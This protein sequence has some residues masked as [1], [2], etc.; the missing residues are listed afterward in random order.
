MTLKSYLNEGGVKS[1]F[2]E[3]AADFFNAPGRAI[4]LGKSVK[5]ASGVV[6][7]KQNETL[8]TK[9]Q[10]WVNERGLYSSVTRP[11]KGVLGGVAYGVISILVGIP[12][13]VGLGLKALALKTNDKA[14]TFHEV[15]ETQLFKERVEN[16]RAEM[17][18][19]LQTDTRQLV[20]DVEFFYTAE[21]N[22]DFMRRRPRQPAAGTIH[23]ITM[24]YLP[25]I[26]Q[27]NYDE[28]T[29]DFVRDL[30]VGASSLSPEVEK[31]LAKVLKL[32]R[33][34]PGKNESV[35]TA[36]NLRNDALRR[37]TQLS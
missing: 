15:V 22:V 8:G 20:K 5:V 36:L 4:W 31:R 18:K 1:S 19:S 11:V 3:K 37:Y 33:E 27:G 32:R 16:E 35:E 9:I 30:G 17:L 24:K 13:I 34:L 2:L 10:S 26:E 12:T 6:T 21:S 7:H 14:K 25:I 29:F 28:T 23:D